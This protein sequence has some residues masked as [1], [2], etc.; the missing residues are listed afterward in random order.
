[1]KFNKL[2]VIIPFALLM[3]AG[4]IPES[5]Q[6]DRSP[7][8]SPGP[9][10]ARVNGGPGVEARDM[11][12][13][14]FIAI[15]GHNISPRQTMWLE[16]G[17]YELTVRIMATSARH[18]LMPRTRDREGYNRIKVELEAGKRYEIRG[19]FD[20]SDRRSPYSVVLYNVS[21]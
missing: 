11:H 21:D 2:F 12:A 9:D 18:T 20:R 16:P 15:D 6:A 8:V 19:Y 3:L 17:E 5:V 1:M 14:E 7:F 4:A 13:V 10:S